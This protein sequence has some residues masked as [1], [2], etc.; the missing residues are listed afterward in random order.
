M[1]ASAAHTAKPELGSMRGTW[2]QR[3]KAH[4]HSLVPPRESSLMVR[5]FSMLSRVVASSLRGA[6]TASVSSGVSVAAQ[7]V[8][9]KY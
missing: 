8:V 4:T 5:N 9:M 2:G 3:Q 7:C 1:A 6:S